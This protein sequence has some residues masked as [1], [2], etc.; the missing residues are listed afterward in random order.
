MLTT[1]FQ[2]HRLVI[3][4]KSCLVPAQKVLWLGKELD[5]HERTI[6]STPRV[7]LHLTALAVLVQCTECN[8][9]L[10]DRVLGYAMWAFRPHQGATL[11]LCSWYRARHSGSRFWPR[12]TLA[13]ARGLSDTLALA[14]RPWRA[15]TTRPLPFTTPIMCA[16]AARL[17]S[18]Y[19]VGLYGP[20][21]GGR[22]LTCPEEVTNQQEA[23][24]YAFDATTRV[25]VRLG[26]Q[27]LTYVGDNAGMLA[28][29]ISMRP[30]L[31]CP[32]LVTMIRR[33]RNRLLWSGLCVCLLWVPSCLQPADPLSR[34]SMQIGSRTTSILQAQ[35]RWQ[36]LLTCL[37][38][39]RYLGHSHVT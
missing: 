16:D 30:P 17:G 1:T 10:I 34:C 25:A 11:S 38:C 18:T 28:L 20:T 21:T 37:A 33:I 26:W 4:S 35:A 22:I 19:Q 3:S 32:K 5:L 8:P 13:M 9:K 23:E 24:L 15:L 36:T 7:L 2:R 27:H 29:A 39:C 12:P 31:R 14:L 6:A